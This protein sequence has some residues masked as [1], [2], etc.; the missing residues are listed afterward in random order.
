M[1]AGHS[2]RVLPSA[3]AIALL[4]A[5]LLHGGPELDFTMRVVLSP[6]RLLIPSSSAVINDDTTPPTSSVDAI[7]PYWHNVSPITITATASDV[8]SGVASVALCYIY[9]P[10]NSTW[11]VWTLFKR[12]NIPPWGWSFYHRSP[13]GE[14]LLYYGSWENGY[15]I[16]DRFILTKNKIVT[17]IE[18]DTLPSHTPADFPLYW[19]LEDVT[20]NVILDSGIF[21]RYDIDA[22]EGSYHG[23]TV[24][25][26]I[27]PVQLVAGKVYRLYF[28]CDSP[29][30]VDNG[31]WKVGATESTYSGL[32]SERRLQWCSRIYPTWS[33]EIGALVA[34]LHFEG[35]NLPVTNGH[36]Q[37]FSVAKDKAGNEGAPAVAV[38][39]CGFD[40]IA[41]DKP[42]LALPENNASDSVLFQTFTWTA[43]TDNLSGIDCY[44]I[45]IDDEVSFTSPYVHEN[46][47][48]TD[49]SYSYTFSANDNYYWR[50][51]AKDNA[52][53]WGE[54]ADNFKLEILAPPGQPTLI[55]P[56]N[57]T[58]DNGSTP[59]FQWMCGSNADNHRLLV[60]NDPDFLS[61]EDNIPL[62]ATDNT[63]TKPAL[64][65]PD[66]NY[67]W[68]VIAINAAGENSSSV[69][70]FVVDTVPPGKPT[71]VSPENNAVKYQILPFTESFKWTQPPENSL[72]LTYHIQIDNEAGFTSPYVHENMAVSDNSY[73]YT[74]TSEGTY[75]WRVRAK[76]AANNWGAWADNFKLAIV[77]SVAPTRWPLIA[78]VVGVILIIGIIAVYVRRR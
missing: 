19:T 78:G 68:K 46:T 32:Y 55:S 5:V 57:G 20:D 37:F 64:G 26:Q 47:A 49:N 44:Q 59:T 54:W 36:Y 9:S 51:R 31:Y 13:V 50:V 65:Y 14:N 8:G 41:P 48:V 45:Q 27:T 52:G 39:A 40:N 10:D 43:S 28:S 42:I 30:N 62:G 7:H 53:N 56:A 58:K 73:S 17:A 24:I 74:F 2:K 11:T 6:P 22:V 70:T 4:L 72:P 77:I 38:A 15:T 75:Y 69:W 25:K 34:W 35:E 33:Y 16:G 76:D 60:D 66:E 67:S 1:R 23:R 71:L 21:A 3:L 61:P 29:S 18:L 12:D 63:W